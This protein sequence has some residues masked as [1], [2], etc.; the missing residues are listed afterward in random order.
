MG[1]LLFAAAAFA[2][3]CA[4]GVWQ[5]QR[6]EEKQLQSARLAV[7]Q[8]AEARALPA[9]P[10]WDG[11]DKQA[12]QHRKIHLQGMF[13]PSR[14]IYWFN[15]RKDLGAGYDILT[16]L[17]LGDGGWVVVNRGF[18]ATL[19]PPQPPQ[20]TAAA[21]TTALSGFLRLPAARRW[22]DPA[23]DPASRLWVVR[24]LSAMAAWMDIAPVAPWF[25]HA[26]TPVPLAANTAA[27]PV[28]PAAAPAVSRV[29][30]VAYALTWFAMAAI[31]AAVTAVYCWQ[32]TAGKRP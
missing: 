16:P 32:Q 18:I 1:F 13:D 5:L 15:H 17:R 31:L 27:R 21:Q 30:H 12:W 9:A 26:E 6:H 8:H 23:D 4:L 2:I 24:D 3:L 7:Q 20:T 11:L 28:A 29:D 14:E 22:F 25:L 10:Q 19:T